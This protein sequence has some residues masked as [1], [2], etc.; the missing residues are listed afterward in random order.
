MVRFTARL[1]ATVCMLYAIDAVAATGWVSDVFYVPLRSGP[2]DS[3]RIIHRGLPSGTVLEILEDD[4]ER[5]FSHVRTPAGVDGWMNSQYVIREPIAAVRLE[6]AN[7]RIK[8]LEAQ[9]AQ[10]GETLSELRESTS[11]ASSENDA[12]ST[13]VAQLD[14][15]LSELK[16]RLRQCDR[17]PEAEREPD[18]S[19]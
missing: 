16:T 14:G 13:Q 18:V 10:R 5:G 4:T 2:S 1:I 6:V 11:E 12:L 19:E 17:D 15:E 8:A 7:K 3:N 9:A